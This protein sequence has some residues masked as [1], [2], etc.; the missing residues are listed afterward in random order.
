MAREVRMAPSPHPL[1]LSEETHTAALPGLES[2]ITDRNNWQRQR[3]GRTASAE[4]A[5]AQAMLTPKMALAP[6]RDLF[7]VPS[8]SR[9]N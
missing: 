2:A 7:D 1:P 3:H 9:M 5:R 8:S 4:P 6:R